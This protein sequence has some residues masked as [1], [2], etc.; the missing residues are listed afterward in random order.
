MIE[1]KYFY[2]ITILLLD[3]NFIS[4]ILTFW[5][6]TN[7]MYLKKSRFQLENSVPGSS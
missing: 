4:S 1:N 7:G 3:T 6:L 5:K 2:E